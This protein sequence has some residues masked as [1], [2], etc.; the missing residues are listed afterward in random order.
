M[1]GGGRCWGG[2]EIIFIEMIHLSFR[3]LIALKVANEIRRREGG[4]GAG[5]GGLD[6][7]A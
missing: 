1:G 5:Q 7:V 6:S 2:V 4:R 3:F